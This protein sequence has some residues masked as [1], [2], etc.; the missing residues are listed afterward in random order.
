MFRPGGAYNG[1]ASGVQQKEVLP[2]HMAGA[3]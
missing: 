3:M 2:V 1:S